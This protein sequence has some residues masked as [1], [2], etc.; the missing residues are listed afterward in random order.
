TPT[1]K[2]VSGSTTTSI[3]PGLYSQITVSGS[4]TLNLSPGV[5]VIAGGGVSLSQNAVLNASGVTF[6]IEGGGFTQSGNAIVN[7]AGMTM[8]NAGSGYTGRGTTGG[9]YG[10]VTLTGNGNMSAPTSGT[11]SGILIFQPGDNTRALTFS[12]NTVLGLTG[13]IDAPGAQLV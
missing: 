4:A 6:I 13:T 3:N 11:Y 9:S 7:G 12:G 10:A 8:V 2:N 1:S 5:Y